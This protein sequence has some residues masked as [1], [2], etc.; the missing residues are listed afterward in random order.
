VL[1]DIIV[2]EDPFN[3]ISDTGANGYLLEYLVKRAIKL[4][5]LAGNPF[6]VYK[7][8]EGYSGL[9]SSNNRLYIIKLILANYKNTLNEYITDSRLLASVFVDVLYKI[10]PEWD[11]ILRDGIQVKNHSPFITASKEALQILLLDDRT[12]INSSL[13]Q[14][15]R[16][17]K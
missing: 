12:S 7:L 14:S 4:A 11:I 17:T 3:L 10:L 8:I 2:S 15:Y 6:T 5:A 13:Q 9:I 1:S 16:W